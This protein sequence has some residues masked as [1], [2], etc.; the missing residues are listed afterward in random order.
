[1]AIP[2]NSECAVS[3]KNVLSLISYVCTENIRV[4]RQAHVTGLDSFCSRNTVELFSI[5]VLV[6][7]GILQPSV[8]KNAGAVTQFHDAHG[9]PYFTRF[10]SRVSITPSASNLQMYVPLGR[11]AASNS[12]L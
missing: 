1:M 7:A 5:S 9:R 12:V 2:F 3:V 11:Y 8:N 10:I 4:Q 6:Y